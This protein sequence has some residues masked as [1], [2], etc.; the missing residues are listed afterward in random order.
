MSFNSQHKHNKKLNAKI[1][2]T[3]TQRSTQS[4]KQTNLEEHNKMKTK[5]GKKMKREGRVNTSFL[6]CSPFWSCSFQASTVWQPI[7]CP[8]SAAIFFSSCLRIHERDII[9]WLKKLRTWMKYRMAKTMCASCLLYSQPYK[10]V[11]VPTHILK[12][13]IP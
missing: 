13:L 2:H 5:K 7:T 12:F 3:H 9:I 6:D 1:T 11:V 4:L 8:S 10:V